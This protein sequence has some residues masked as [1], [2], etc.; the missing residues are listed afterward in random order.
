M[1]NA[2]NIG[3]TNNPMGEVF[4]GGSIREVEFNITSGTQVTADERFGAENIMLS[5][6]NNSGVFSNPAGILGTP[7]ASIGERNE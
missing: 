5:N 3:T 4:S 2:R 1:R 7:S 6:V